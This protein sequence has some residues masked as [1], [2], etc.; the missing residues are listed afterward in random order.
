MKENINIVWSTKFG[1]AYPLAHIVT[2]YVGVEPPFTY[3]TVKSYLFKV[4][5]FTGMSVGGY[6][7]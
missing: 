7:G 1:K 4:S 6:G 3:A 2:K 5:G